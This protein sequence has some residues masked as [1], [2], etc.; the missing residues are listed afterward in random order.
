MI[1]GANVPPQNGDV[2]IANI[3]GRAEVRRYYRRDGVVELVPD[4]PAS[5]AET[6]RVSPETPVWTVIQI[7]K[8][9]RRRSG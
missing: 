4:N 9:P 6:F 5:G 8:V 3:E 2:V 7:Q 1:A